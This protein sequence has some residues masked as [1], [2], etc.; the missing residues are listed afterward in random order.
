MTKK[1]PD[2]Y[3][4]VRIV[5]ERHRQQGAEQERAKIVAFLRETIFNCTYAD[6][7][8]AIEACEHL[9]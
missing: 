4:D 9:K 7:P 8:S 6:I 1:M 2:I 3:A 5:V